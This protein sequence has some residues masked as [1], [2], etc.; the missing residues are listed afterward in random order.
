VATITPTPI[1][2][3]KSVPRVPSNRRVRLNR[4]VGYS[5]LA[6]VLVAGSFSALLY[7]RYSRDL[8]AAQQLQLAD[9]G[10]VVQTKVGLIEYATYGEG[11]PVLLSH[12]LLG[13]FNHGLLIARTQ[14]GEGFHAI[15]VSRFGYLGTPLPADA[16]PAA[17]ADAYAALLDT[18]GIQRVAIAGTSS[19]GASAIQFALRHPD[20]TSA[21]VLLSATG[22][23]DTPPPP[24]SLMNLL[25]GSDFVFWTWQTYAGSSLLSAM[26][27]TSGSQAQPNDPFLRELMPRFLPI[28]DRTAG[29]LNDMYVTNSEFKDFAFERIAV[30]TLAI[31]AVDDTLAPLD[32]ARARAER[33]PGVRF[34]TLGSGGHL[35]LAQHERVKAELAD[36]LGSAH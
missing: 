29:A 34:I 6:L 11:P 24:R 4:V 15:A 8:Q 36:F 33:I 22:P 31:N 16:S 35:L 23:G 12:E 7:T 13:G 14:F 30:P 20:R 19:G 10:R 32:Y 21:L 25:F 26:G 1:S 3:A 18:L 28:S 17:Q 2:H 5:G 27:V 9:G